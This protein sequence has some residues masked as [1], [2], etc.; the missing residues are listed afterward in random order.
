MS[1][2][3]TIWTHV[4]SCGYVPSQIEY[5]VWVAI[6]KLLPILGESISHWEVKPTGY[7]NERSLSLQ[8]IPSILKRLSSVR[9]VETQTFTKPVLRKLSQF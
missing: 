7:G 4:V 9:Y 6:V 5:A 2:F 3:L 1:E 8:A